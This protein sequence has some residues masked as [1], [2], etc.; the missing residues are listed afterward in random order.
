MIS[1][2]KK[3]IYFHFTPIENSDESDRDPI[4]HLSLV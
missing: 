3:V 1:G 2:E 4:Y